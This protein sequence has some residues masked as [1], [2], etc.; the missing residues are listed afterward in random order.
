[1]ADMEIKGSKKYLS[2]L[3]KHLEIEHPKTIGK[4][5]MDI[6]HERKKKRGKK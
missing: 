6:E 2:Y 1:M 5:E 3:K 4:I